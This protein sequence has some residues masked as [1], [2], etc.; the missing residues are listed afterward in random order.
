METRD[1][2]EPFARIDVSRAKQ[3]L[4]RGGAVLIDVREPHEYEEAHIPGVSLIP[5]DSLLRRAGEL[6]PDK[7]VIF[8]CR[9]GRRS[10]LAAEIAAA[11]GFENALYNLE[12]GMLAWLEAG[13]PVEA[14]PIR[15]AT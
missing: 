1:P 4:R 6:P 5:V 3:I 9:S 14:T 13:E 15:V 8:I 12:G 2:R 11:S 7:D 10:A